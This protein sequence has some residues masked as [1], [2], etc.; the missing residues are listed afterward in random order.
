MLL[1]LVYLIC[2]LIA[3]LLDSS[4]TAQMTRCI[5]HKVHRERAWGKQSL[6]FSL[7]IQLRF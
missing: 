7:L 5:R 4:L 1:R 3:S 2:V 6:A